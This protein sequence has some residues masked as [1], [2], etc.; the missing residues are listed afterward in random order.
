MWL[1][2]IKDLR[3][4]LVLDTFARHPRLIYKELSYKNLGKACLYM[5]VLLK[6]RDVV[7]VVNLRT[8]LGLAVHT[9]S[10][11]SVRTVE[12]EHEFV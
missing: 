11:I 12:F 9:W 5:L 3:C 4:H 7:V 8:S 10:L 2:P 6:G 1:K